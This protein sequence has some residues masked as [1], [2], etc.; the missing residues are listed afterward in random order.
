V[1]TVAKITQGAAGDYAEYLDG[2]TRST[3]AGDYY[4]KD[5]DRALLDVRRPDTGQPLRPV[6]SNGTAVAA[7]DATFSAPKSVSAVWA[8][9]D[10]RLRAEIEAAHE[11][12]IDR[13]L[14]YA[15]DQVAMIRQ[16]VSR[17][18]VIHTT[19]AGLVATSWRH[20]TA[21]AVIDQPPDPQLHSHV[22]LHGALRA[23]GQVMAID[24]RAWLTHRRELG[25]AYRTE[26]AFE[27]R[28]L[29]FEIDR[30]T[31]RAQ[32]YFEI[33]GVPAELIERWSSRDRQIRAAIDAR[34]DE[35]QA[36]LA[37]EV[38]AG[39]EAGTAALERLRR[40]WD[41]GLAPAENRAVTLLTRAPK[42]A[43][44]TH[45]D[46]DAAWGSTAHELGFDPAGLQTLRAPRPGLTTASED[47]VL[48]RLT[49]FDATF[50]DHAARAV[51][52]EASVGSRI[53]AGLAVL[54]D[55]RG[56]GH[57]LALEGGRS[58]TRAHRATE[59]ATE[60][61][62]DELSG[63]Q[64]SAVPRPLVDREIARLAQQ[65][66]RDGD[67]LTAEQV[68]A[69][70]LACAERQLTVIEGQAGT[71]KSTVLS[72]VA[73][74]H[75]A[76]GRQILVTSTAALAAQRLADDLQAAGVTANAS[77]TAALHAA[78]STGRAGLGP[79][80][81]VIHDEAAL[82]STRDQHRLLTAV[83]A[84]G[85]R[86][87]EVGDPEQSRPVGAAG[88]WPTIERAAHASGSRVELTRN[89]RAHDPEDRRDQQHFREGEIDQALRGYQERG[90]VTWSDEPR[91]AEDRALEAA[92]ADRQAGRRTLVIAQTSNEQLDAL[93]A[94]AQAIRHHA[95]HLGDDTLSVPGRP[96]G[97]RAGDPVQIRRTFTHPGYPEPIRNGTV[98]EVSRVDGATGQLELQAGDGRR[99]E[100]DREQLAAPDIRLA[101][102]QHPFPAQGQTTDTTH[103]IVS[104]HAT[105]EGSYVALSRARERTDIYANLEQAAE[106]DERDP[107]ATL[108]E[109]MSRTEPD[110]PSIDYPLA[111]EN[112]IATMPDMT[113]TPALGEHDSEHERHEAPGYLTAAVGQR[114]GPGDPRQASWQHAADAIGDYR[115]RYQ[116]PADEPSA[117]GP[118]PPAGRFSQR[119]DRAQTADRVAVAASQLGLEPP[120]LGPAVVRE[121]DRDRVI[122]EQSSGY[123][124]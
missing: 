49:E 68:E 12:A 66:S 29:G 61:T 114:P 77:S 24:S 33:Q 97:L 16:R 41:S 7:L 34:L 111:H 47:Q 10:S 38:A 109:R 115:S 23:D 123:E 51:A 59:R 42:P 69:I 90:R 60:R 5:G 28:A 78:L 13:A 64:A 113:A 110:I 46:L 14:Y 79:H 31:G 40:L 36:R 83:Q 107:F 19:A 108:A 8:V 18:H 20:S 37:A 67:A 54:D 99:L 98:A 94:R 86:L 103:L 57:V 92:E 105:R 70:R 101:Y 117:L 96:Y 44:G 58:T 3:A 91:R 25:A 21:R 81:T 85:A 119:H 55:A 71:G 50:P 80:T 4:L 65:L 93:N 82:A 95:G 62:I 104:E 39:G 22:L 72:A 120:N 84:G 26:L 87:I 63:A 75:R 27:L 32:R 56:R 30:G 43:A 74:A 15:V 6:G 124:P 122:G 17:D 1:L 52:L 76:D 53:D 9:A 112:R 118:V 2:R 89:V 121:A 100:L 88:L 102:V 106:S 45:A 48:R 116:I 11:R 35:R 73:R